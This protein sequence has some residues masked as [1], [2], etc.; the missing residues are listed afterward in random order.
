MSKD[1]FKDMD[2]ET[3]V[4]KLSTLISQLEGGKLGFDETLETYREAFEYYSFCSDYLKSAES[5][6]RE[7]NEAMS[8][9]SPISEG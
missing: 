6:I 5:K 3:A 1:K 8:R 2:Y 9:I 4:N 7:M